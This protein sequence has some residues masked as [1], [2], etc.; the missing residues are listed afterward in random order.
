MCHKK[1]PEKNK[2]FIKKNL[3]CDE[4]LATFEVAA[5]SLGDDKILLFIFY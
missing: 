5:V 2:F 4:K 3:Q 1:R